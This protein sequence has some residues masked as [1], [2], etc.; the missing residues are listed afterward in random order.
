MRVGS[1]GAGR[2][3]TRIG[4]DGGMASDEQQQGLVFPADAEGSGARRP[5]AAPS[6]RTRCA[7]STRPARVAAEQETDWR[8]GLPGALPAAASRRG[9]PPRRRRTPSRQDGLDSLHDRMRSLDEH[10]EEQPLDEVARRRARPRGRRGGRHG[11]AGRRAGAAVPRRAAARQRHPSPPRGL[12]RGRD[13]RAD[14][15]RGDRPGAG[16]PRLAAARGAH[17]RR[18]R[19]RRRDGSAA[20]ADAVGCPRGRG[21]PRPP[22]H[23][24]AGAAAGQ[25]GRGLADRAGAPDTDGRA[26]RDGRRRPARRRAGRRALAARAAG[27]AG[28]RQLRLRRRR[29]QHPRLDGG[30]RADHPAADGSRRRGAGVPGH[31]DRRVRRTARGGRP[32]DAAYDGRSGRSKTLGRPLRALS[33]GRLLRRSYVPG[34]G[35]R[36]QRLDGAAA[37]AELRAGQAAPA[38]AGDGRPRGRA[39]WS[40]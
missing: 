4:H 26:G 18:A 25:G 19:C 20:V 21:R 16:Q 38:L 3:T 5:S 2:R 10:G 36:H 31:A 13:H 9:W 40:R 7:R 29:H 14:R 32:L 12:G 17:G 28:A 33:G 23:L 1:G 15:G 22:G 39:R 35:P 34:L 11:A 24:E 8:S 30:R 27:D 6:P 37:G